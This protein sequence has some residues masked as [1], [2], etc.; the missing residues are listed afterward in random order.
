MTF[1]SARLPALS[2][3]VLALHRGSREW[4]A[5]SFA[6]RACELLQGLIPHSACLWGSV[7]AAAPVDA[8]LAGPGL[9]AEGLSAET[10]ARCLAGQGP[11]PDLQAEHTEP[12]AARRVRLQLWQDRPAASADA[13]LADS[14]AL[15]FLMP[16]L[17][18]AQRENRLS[19]LHSGADQGA[20][21][22][23]ALCDA[24]GVLQQVDAQ[25]L[26]LLRA[27]WRN[28][29]NAR[30]PAAL[31]DW[32]AQLRGGLADAQPASGAHEPAPAPFHGRQITLLPVRS[33][34]LW[35]LEV[36]RRAPV[37]RLSRRQRDIAL[38]YA[39][40]HTGPQI[41]TRLGLSSSTV[42]NHLGVIFKKLAVSNKVQLLNAV[43]GREN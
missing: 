10:L 36:R 37:D 41:A 5:S 34:E 27:E 8:P 33:G 26:A 25:G 30:L 18:E 1:E 24:D 15:Q 28:W 42:N 29:S 43:R 32:L 38:L 13:T 3:A 16:H 23:H 4:P 21:R 7:P 40:G 9:H 11:P 2:Q 35:L 17:V 6:A 19:R 20:L 14:Q 39:E 12:L 22:S 31:V